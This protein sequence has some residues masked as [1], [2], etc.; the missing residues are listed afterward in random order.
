MTE[1]IANKLIQLA[2]QPFDAKQTTLLVQECAVWPNECITAFLEAWYKAAS[3]QEDYRDD[4]LQALEQARTSLPFD[5][6]EQPDL[7][8]KLAELESE[9][10][11]QQKAKL[12]YKPIYNWPLPPQRPIISNERFEFLNREQLKG[13]NPFPFRDAHQDRY[14]LFNLREK[15]NRAFWGGHPVFNKVFQIERSVIVAGKSGS[16]R[17]ALAYGLYYYAIQRNS[18]AVYVGS[19]QPRIDTFKVQFSHYV[20]DFILSFPHYLRRLT[21]VQR[22]LVARFLASSIPI[23][24]LLA[25]IDTGIIRNKISLRGNQEEANKQLRLLAKAIS[26]SLVSELNL[27]DLTWIS[28]LGSIVKAF[29]FDKVFLLL[30]YDDVG[31]GSD[32]LAEH[33]LP[34]IDDWQTRGL[35]TVLFVPD[36]I[37]SPNDVPRVVDWMR[38]DWTQTQLTQMIRWRYK[39]FAGE[40]R[41]IYELFEAK[42]AFD[43][44]LEKCLLDDATLTYNPG[45]FISLWKKMIASLGKDERIHQSHVENACNDL[46]ELVRP[47][48][49]TRTTIALQ[50]TDKLEQ[51]IH[52]V[53]VEYFSQADLEEL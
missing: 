15:P 8:Y 14:S 6:I 28:Q 3:T 24:T 39:A 16:G 29:D 21:V 36:G 51:Q 47:V 43:A 18:W 10:V 40:R 25:D 1:K 37:L 46:S 42:E 11:A 26:D 12:E 30:D 35:L 13:L 22:N 17:T 4:W 48:D 38:L 53:F 45:K 49:V 32:W 19:S 23:D 34:F 52:E 27:S 9:I 7:L 44:L 31:T 41:E 33:I 5:K 2:T 20:Y 50:N